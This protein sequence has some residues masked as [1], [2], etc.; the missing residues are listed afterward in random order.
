[1]KNIIK[2][3]AAS[4]LL[5]GLFFIPVLSPAEASGSIV[6]DNNDKSQAEIE[7]ID[8]MQILESK[9]KVRGIFMSKVRR[10]FSKRSKD[11]KNRI[12]VSNSNLVND[13]RSQAEVESQEQILYIQIIS[14]YRKLKPID[15]IQANGDPYS[16]ISNLMGA[17]YGEE[18][19]AILN[20]R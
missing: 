1:M 9:S 13:D 14:T 6:I 18:V 19:S 17:N 3:I 5:G 4:F 12:F 11:T 16:I 8:E 2:N 20:I 15:P 7:A 10:L